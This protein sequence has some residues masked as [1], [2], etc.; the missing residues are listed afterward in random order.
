[1]PTAGKSHDI[2]IADISGSPKRGFMSFRDQTRKEPFSLQ[3]FQTI[4]PRQLTM[5]ELTQAELPPQVEMIFSQEKWQGGMGGVI[6]R[7]HQYT[8][9]SGFKVDASSP[10]GIIRLARDVVVTTDDSAPNEYVPSGFADSGSQIW[11]FQGRD[12]YSWDYTNKTWDIQTEPIAVAKVYRNGTIFDQW[13]IAPAWAD[14]AGSGGSYTADD[15]PT[16]YIYKELDDAQWTLAA[17]ASA[18]PDAFKYFTVANSKLWG[19]YVSDRADTS[20]DIDSYLKQISSASGTHSSGTSFSWSHTV[21]TGSDRLLLVAVSTNNDVSTSAV[22]AG[23]VSMSS[24]GSRDQVHETVDYEISLWKL[25]APGTG[26]ITINVTMDGT[27]TNAA[28]ASSEW[29]GA[30]Q[31]TPV[32]TISVASGN[33][34]TSNSMASSTT[35]GEIAVQA[36]MTR[37]ATP[38]AG[39]GDTEIVEANDGNALYSTLYQEVA[40][41]GTTTI[42]PTFGNT[43]FAGVQ[44]V[45][46]PS[47]TSGNLNIDADPTSALS[48]GDVIVVASEMMLVTLSTTSGGNRLTVVRGYRGTATATHAAGSSIYKITTNK[49]HVRSSLDPT[50]TGSFASATEIGNQETAITGLHGIENDLIIFKEDGIYRLESGGTITN[51]RPEL[52]AWRHPDNGRGGFAW[53]DKVFYPLGLGGLLELDVQTLLIKD[54]SLS[55]S[56]PDQTQ[57]HGRIVAMHGE[58]TTLFALVLE[59][60]NTRYHLLC[61]SYATVGDTTDYRWHH[62]GSISYTTATDPDHAALFAEA[63]PSG[64]VVRRRINIGV[65]STGSNLFPYYMTA[66]GDGDDA[67]TNDTDAYL[68]TT[69][70]DKNLPRVVAHLSDIEVETKN[71]G[72]GGS[73]NRIEVKYRLDGGSWVYW[74]GSQG[75]STLTS[76]RQILSVGST[77]VATFNK[78]DIQFIPIRQSG[79]TTSGP[80]IHSF[81]VKSQLRPSAIKSIPIDLHIADNQTILNGAR[82]TTSKGDLSQLKTWNNQS[83]E[84]KLTTPDGET[85]QIVFLPG[86]FR[87]TQI[88]HESKRRPEYRVQALLAEV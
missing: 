81:V 34:G 87:V 82:Q 22:T 70:Y 14:D 64:A 3:D 30:D 28:G 13:V 79:G 24:V 77:T 16:S 61:A 10:A 32:D 52:S 41:G 18:H 69:V 25:V 85:F 63:V 26:S 7:L 46:N 23:G 1:M 43:T 75:S 50:N 49:H 57:F 66:E 47:A 56:M 40:T 78:L 4:Q 20:I 2:T 71:L 76:N 6:D 73:D 80:E 38:A 67:V 29:L 45:I 53:N 12:V 51:L 11:S 58:P 84:L 37:A 44:C 36:L 8:Y 88:A 83:E 19:G 74:T 5:G 31:S 35:A 9:A 68:I 17:K 48:A 39:S 54:V 62:C 86:M 55:L 27:P 65:E 59:A 42:A 33:P 21:T 15:E 60:A 72:T